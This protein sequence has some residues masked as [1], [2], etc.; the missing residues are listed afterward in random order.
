MPARTLVTL[1]LVLSPA[2]AQT[3]PR[4]VQRFLETPLTTPDV[5]AAEI[6]QYLMARAP[7][8]PQVSSADEW[9]RRAA[10][11]RGRMLDEVVFHGWPKEWV[12][13]PLKVEDLGVSATGPGY[14]MRKLRYEIVPGFWSAA[15]L[16]EPERMNGKLP[17]MVNVNGH[18]Q[19]GKALEYKQKRCI[20]QAK[21][22]ILA[23]N[24]EWINFGELTHKENAHWFQ[25]HL[26]LAGASGVG[27]FYLAMRKGVDYL[28][29]HPN[30][31]RARI[32][33]T[34]LSGGGWQTITL[35]ALDE[36]VALSIPVAGYSTLEARIE[37]TADTG[38][39]EQN[40]AD[41][42]RV[43]DYSHL[44]A[45]RAPRPTLLIFN[46][47]DDCC[48]RAP[49]VK[50][51]VHDDVRP[52]F[53][54]YG[55]ED[56][57]GFHQNTDPSDHNY[58]LDNRIQFYKFVAKQF[59]MAPVDG[60][61]PSDAE[62][63]TRE[64]L[65]VG[66]PADNLTVLG[67]AREFAKRIQRQTPTPERLRQVVR[68][69][70]VSV[71]HAWPVTN[72]NQKGLETLAYKLEFSD[73][74]AATALWLKSLSAADA[75][76]ATLVID[77]QGKRAASVEVSDRVNRGE[78]VLAVDA[79][80]NGDAAPQKPGSSDYA[81]MFSALGERPLGIEAAQLI[82]AARW[83]R[84]TMRAPSIRLVSRG[85]RSQVVALAAKAL[86]PA[87]FDTVVVNEGM[88]SF[89]HL[90]ETPVEYQA[91]PD[92]FCRDLYREFDI[93]DLAQLGR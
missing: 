45:M 24:L 12:A 10:Q 54:L 2:L 17:A 39:I 82:A 19:P 1:L 6:R 53:R 70:P 40:P 74:L 26:D 29:D 47:E 7:R 61:I 36:R 68:F 59:G 43:G 71:K 41:M 80:F 55:A 73:G 88:K 27:L 75:P 63:K 28:Y 33:V 18:G 4:Q 8:L 78:Q 9:T 90:L 25:A 20:N 50:P 44:T 22:G 84:Q 14:R 49:L 48:F 89:Q 67:L 15:I 62:I 52:F 86:E 93:R 34:G 58:Q 23:L 69:Q 5:V 83:L 3:N 91:A 42:M 79:I 92:L 46:A 16:Y 81:Q 76:P 64:E 57:F 66:L 21:R 65:N 87:A 32:G 51:G 60:E 11:L 56:R 72:S 35:S 38:D 85:I 30:A 31:D 13:A 77:D 37:R